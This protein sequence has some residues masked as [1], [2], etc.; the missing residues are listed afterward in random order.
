MC[1]ISLGV[2]GGMGIYTGQGCVVLDYFYGL[3]PFDEVLKVFERYPLNIP[4]QVGYVEFVSKCTYVSMHGGLGT[5]NP[6]LD[7]GSTVTI[8]HVSIHQQYF[9]NFTICLMIS[10]NNI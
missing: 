1:I 2:F 9:L 5:P 4:V 3:I 6:H 10:I 8:W 7:Q